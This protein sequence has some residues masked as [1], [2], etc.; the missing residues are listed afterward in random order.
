MQFWSL[1]DVR[2]YRL[3]DKSAKKL[4]RIVKLPNIERRE[5]LSL[6]IENT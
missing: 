1:Y 2:V 5:R 3:A 4:C 6:Y